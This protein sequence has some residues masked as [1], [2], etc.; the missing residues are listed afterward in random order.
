VPAEEAERAFSTQKLYKRF[1]IVAAGP[2][3]NLLLAYVLFTA[4]FWF[5]QPMASSRVGAVAYQSAAWSAGLRAQDRIVR[6]N[7][8]AVDSWNSVEDFLKKK[9]GQKVSFDIQRGDQSLSLQIPVEKI[10][11]KNVYGEEE[12]V[13]GVPSMSSN[14]IEAM[15]GV[16]NPES[17][18][19]RAGLRTGDVIIRV[20]NRSV[21]YWEEFRDVLS[22]VWETQKPTTL[23]V[24]RG[25]SLSPPKPSETTITLVFPNKPQTFS[26]PWQGLDQLGIYPSEVFVHA[27]SPGSPAETG[28]LQAGDRVV[29]LSDE[30]IFGFDS[31]LE[32]VQKAG[33]A[34]QTVPFHLERAGKPVTLSLKPT[35][36]EIEDPLTHQKSKRFLVGFK[37][38]LALKES[39]L[40]K[41]QIRAPGQL[42][43][44]AVTETHE[45]AEKM[46]ISIG[47]LI[48]G[49]ISVKNLGGPI[50][51]A[52]VAGKSLDAGFVPFLQMMALISIN[53]F[54][55]NL[56]P[57]PVLDGGHLL[58][59]SIEAVK[60]KPVSLRTMEMASQVGMVFI[61]ILVALTFFNDISRIVFR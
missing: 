44:H 25:M 35:E 52:S 49:K 39:E 17:V 50:M 15:I 8:I 2:L 4:V 40:T 16:S 43:A 18:A 5:G 31:I 29:K 30:T 23:T 26:L 55:L 51:I 47:K 13:G 14:P 37:P 20:D 1:L 7:G 53:L 54:L 22:G 41:L 11:A 45:L 9:E 46:V 28:G 10:R 42:I 34:G 6:L 59:F 32:A 58:F 19:Y 57:V 24:K 12:E 38:M 27:V 33:S 56:L 61:L 60:G 36:T 3:S 21:T 48:F